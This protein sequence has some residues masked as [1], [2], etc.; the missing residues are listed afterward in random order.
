MTGT[1]GPLFDPVFGQ[2]NG[3]DHSDEAWTRALVE[4]EA[5]LARAA[6][7]SGLVGTAT[8]EALTALAAEPGRIPDADPA[9]LG[10]ASVSGGNPVIPLVS[11]LRAEVTQT[12]PHAV[13][14]EVHVGATSQ[15]VMD[16][17][18]A[19]FVHRTATNLAGHAD[20]AVAA[21]AAIAHEHRETPLVARTLG[22]QALP[23]TF[24]LVAAGWGASIRRAA[25][26]AV[27]AAH[28]VPVQFGGAA[29]TLA[30]L[31]P[32]GLALA[33][34]L[35]DELGLPRAVS[36][37][38]TD[39][40]V[41]TLYA[42]ALGATAGAAAKA[43]GVIIRHAATE[44]GEL[45]V[46]DGGGSSAMPHKRNPTAAIEAR[47]A[48]M[49]APGLVATMHAAAAHEHQRAAGAWHAEWETLSDLQR[50]TV[51]ALA[52]LADA[53][54][55]L[56]VH[57]EAMAQNLNMTGG[58]LLAERVVVALGREVLDARGL[59]TEACRN[60][61][62]LDR[63]PRLVEALGADRLAELLDPAGYTGH[64][65]DLVDRLLPTLTPISELDPQEGHR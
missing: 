48:A 29:G 5:A 36:P 50:L 12:D 57:P 35:A 42:G 55:D 44:I 34:A 45:S 1:R 4:V 27:R 20:R 16:S 40:T 25:A 24:G 21:C 59:V 26:E 38:H 32:H 63:D 2:T 62:R 17:A 10:P 23:T 6:S 43:A 54:E 31:H 9:T 53:L 3:V 60:S 30:A 11:A 18:V 33:D 58:A 37:W 61:E 39:R 49:R 47:A 19:L 64:A 51:G 56:V 28:G 14:S 15:D 52:R 46:R 7:R 13:A 41:L 65:T 8:A 22:Q